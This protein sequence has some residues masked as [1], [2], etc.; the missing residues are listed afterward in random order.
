[1]YWFLCSSKSWIRLGLVRPNHRSD[2][3]TNNLTLPS[4]SDWLIGDN[5]LRSVYSLYDFGDYDSSGKMGNPYVKLLSIINPDEA[6]VDFHKQRGGTPRT[7]ITFV[8]L[9]GVSVAP[10][11][12]IS[13]DISKSLEM[14]GTWMP[15][16]LAV[17]ALNAL[18]VVICSIVWLISFIR[19]RRRR[20]TAR[21]PRGRVSP[22]PMN[23]MNSY[24]AGAPPTPNGPTSPGSVH[25]YEPVSMALTEDTF[26]PPSP[27]FHGKASMGDRPKSSV[28]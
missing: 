26:V 14:I 6:S 27:A 16:I 12:Y 10:S 20:A 3:S 19:K 8:G 1:M 11:F 25:V 4:S 15:A 7:N 24:I 28:Y 2:I 5:V 21:H 23:P 17:V 18:I 22:L 13:N 9:D